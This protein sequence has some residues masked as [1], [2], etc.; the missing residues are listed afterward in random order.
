[1]PAATKASE[2]PQ[3]IAIVL[4]QPFRRVDELRLQPVDSSSHVYKDNRDRISVCRLGAG[5]DGVELDRQPLQPEIARDEA[6]P[7][8]HRPI[9]D[10]R[11]ALDTRRTRRQTSENEWTK[12]N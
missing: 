12:R 4:V 3:R 2:E 5:Q 1:M 8:P 7:M 10:V 11:T 6:R 9:E